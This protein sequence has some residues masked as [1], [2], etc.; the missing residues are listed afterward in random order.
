MYL[1][2]IDKYPDLAEGR[3][4]AMRCWDEREVRTVVWPSTHPHPKG[5]VCLLQGRAEFVEKYY[6][7]VR[8]LR[9]RGFAVVTMDWR[10]QGGSE[11]LLDDP[12]KGDVRRFSDYG[13][14]LHQ[15]LHESVLPDFPPPHFALSHSMG[16]LILL[17]QL[18]SLRAVFERAVLCA[19]LIELATERRKLLSMRLKQSTVR[20]ISSFLRLLGRGKHFMPGAE[21]API[22]RLGFDVNT[23][24]SDG[25]TYD[26]NRQYLIDFPELA[27]AGPTVRWIHEACKAM[28]RLQSSEMQSSI[29]TPTLIITASQDRVVNTKTAEYF[30]ST[31]RAIHAVPIPGS[32][33]EIMMERKI[34]REQFWAAF[35]AFIPGQN[36]LTNENIYMP[37]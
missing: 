3:V 8:N 14:D 34:L 1:R 11:R 13:R 22:D 2:N 31:A 16:G 6:E 20:K 5:T 15:F 10:G 37:R 28:D 23:L 27:I 33:H 25:P 7:V 4:K 19:P 26:R 18:P 21:R 30:A 12:L 29:Y 9:A 32:R 24:T 36:T 17:E 35:D